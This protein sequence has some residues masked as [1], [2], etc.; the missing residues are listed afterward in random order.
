MAV[1]SGVGLGDRLLRSGAYL[2]TAGS[3]TILG[4]TDI[5]TQPANGAFTTQR[6][7]GDPTFGSPY[8]WLGTLTTGVSIA[9]YL[10]IFDGTNTFDSVTTI[11]PVG[12]WLGVATVVDAGAGQVRLYSVMTPGGT[13]TLI[14][15]LAVA[16]SGIVFTSTSEV[17]NGDPGTTL[18]TATTRDRVFASALSAAQITAEFA[19]RTAVLPALADTPLSAPSDLVDISGNGH[20]WAA[21]GVPTFLAGP[22][23][24]ITAVTPTALVTTFDL[25]KASNEIFQYTAVAADVELSVSATDD[26]G[27]NTLTLGVYTGTVNALVLY[28]ALLSTQRRAIEVPVTPGTTYFFR[29]ANTAAPTVLGAD[30]AFSIQRQ[31]AE[32]LTLGSLLIG[33]DSHDFPP[34]IVSLT[35]SSILGIPPIIGGTQ[36]MDTVSSGIV[37]M[38]NESVPGRLRRFSADLTTE[39]A[40]IDL[41]GAPSIDGIRSDRNDTF[42]VATHKGGIATVYA[43]SGSGVLSGT[44]WIIPNTAFTHAPN[45]AGTILYW[46][47]STGTAAL[48]DIH[49]WDLVNDVALADFLPDQAPAFVTQDMLALSDGTFLIG[50]R[51]VSF[52]FK[53]EHRSALGVLLRTYDFGNIVADAALN[54]RMSLSQDQLSFWLKTNPILNTDADTQLLQQT[55]ISDGTLLT[56]TTFWT[57]KS[58]LGPVIASPAALPPFGPGPSTPIT[59]LFSSVTPPAPGPAACPTGLGMALGSGTPACASDL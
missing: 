34:T 12:T 49:A 11:L 55:R 17:C 31:P 57:F 21:S 59:V 24:T 43:I 29:I 7:F 26:G 2:N 22:A 37:L 35:G 47:R 58:G 19:A 46:S 18:G 4:W 25:R 36:Y 53:V 48:T 30:V 33:D 13:P 27:T 51:L 44:S 28:L 41:P 6:L 23:T 56:A 9:V 20:D 16:V 5:P 3:F 45:A 39:F 8:I 10:E 14:D 50:Y 42:Y 52:D 15:T 40:V 54:Y 38:D 1:Q 32:D